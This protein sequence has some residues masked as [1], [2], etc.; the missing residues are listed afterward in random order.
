VSDCPSIAQI[1]ASNFAD[2]CKPNSVSRFDCLKHEFEK[3]YD[4][5]DPNVGD[6]RTLVISVELVENVSAS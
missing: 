2:A 5:Y 6:V 1:F 4:N 3:V